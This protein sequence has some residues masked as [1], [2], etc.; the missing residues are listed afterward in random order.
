M[1]LLAILSVSLLTALAACGGEET[2]S[3]TITSHFTVDSPSPTSP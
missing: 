2:G 1:R 3:A